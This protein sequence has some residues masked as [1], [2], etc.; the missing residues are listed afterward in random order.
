MR[1]VNIQVCDLYFFFFFFAFV[2]VVKSVY[3][4]F[5]VVCLGVIP[6]SPPPPPRYINTFT[7]HRFVQQTGIILKLILLQRSLTDIR[8]G[9]TYCPLSDRTSASWR[10]GRWPLR[11][12]PSDAR[13]VGSNRYFF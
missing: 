11:S 4:A 10:C 8:N 2:F 5:V 3:F 9:N 13:S 1:E 6:P 12:R 7:R